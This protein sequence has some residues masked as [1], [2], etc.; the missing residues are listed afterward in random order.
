MTTL[1]VFAND[2]LV[3]VHYKYFFKSD[4]VAWIGFVSKTNKYLYNLA[5]DSRKSVCGPGFY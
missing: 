4:N 3:H 5:L 2:K 1:I